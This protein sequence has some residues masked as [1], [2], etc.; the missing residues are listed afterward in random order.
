MGRKVLTSGL[1]RIDEGEPMKRR[2]KPAYGPIGSV[3]TAT[4]RTE[5]LIPSFLW[6]C[7][8]LRLT[9][10]ERQSVNEIKRASKREGY[11]ESEDASLD[12]NETLFDVLNNHALPYFYFGSHPGDGSDYGF[13]LDEGFEESFDGMKVSDLSEVPHGYTGEVLHVNDHGNMTLYAYTRG[14]GRELWGIV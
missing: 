1:C 11:F 13:W 5:D 8:R 6:E 12:L 2:Q 9:R 7:D 3:S 10:K 14:R 4:T